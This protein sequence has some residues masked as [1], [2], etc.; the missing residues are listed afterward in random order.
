MVFVVVLLF[1]RCG[2]DIVGWLVDWLVVARFC[3]HCW[4]VVVVVRV[5]G[6]VDRIDLVLVDATER[7]ETKM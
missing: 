5:R 4:R 1:G 7:E 3:R 6:A 2:C